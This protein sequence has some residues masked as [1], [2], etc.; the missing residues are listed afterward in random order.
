[1]HVRV[2]MKVTHYLPQEESASARGLARCKAG[3]CHARVLALAAVL[4]QHVGGQRKDG[5]PRR[6]RPVLRL[7][8][9]KCAR[10]VCACVQAGSAGGAVSGLECTHR[11]SRMYGHTPGPDITGI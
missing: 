10:R 4:L 5:Q 2:S 7:P 11:G 3:T 8:C 6:V 1:M 9:A